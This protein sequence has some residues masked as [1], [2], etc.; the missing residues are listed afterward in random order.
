[1]TVAQRLGDPLLESA[2]YHNL[3]ETYFWSGDL[4][5]AHVYFE[6]AF[7]IFDHV[8]PQALTRSVG[9]RWMV[10]AALLS[11]Q[12]LILGRPEQVIAWGESIAERA[13]SSSHPYS[14]AFG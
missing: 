12:N 3:G 6:R 14:K 10:I 5:T 1:M 2:S 4:P 11:V 9:Y 13:R 8:S 7:D